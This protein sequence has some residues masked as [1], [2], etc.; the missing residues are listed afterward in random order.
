M[1]SADLQLFETPPHSRVR[2]RHV[3]AAK[4]V[5]VP[6]RSICSSFSDQEALWSS[7]FREIAGVLKVKRIIA[8]E[9]APRGSLM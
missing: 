9:T 2:G 7:S 4:M 1:T 8:A 6:N 3:T 5:K